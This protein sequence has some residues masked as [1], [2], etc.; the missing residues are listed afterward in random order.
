MVSSVCSCCGTAMY[1][2]GKVVVFMGVVTGMVAATVYLFN[3]VVELK[4]F[5]VQ[6]NIGKL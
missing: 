2:L 5:A 4:P 3:I 1:T 6:S